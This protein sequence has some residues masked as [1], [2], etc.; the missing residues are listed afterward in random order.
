MTDDEIENR[1]YLYVKLKHT[2]PVLSDSS[3]S[4]ED[5]LVIYYMLNNIETMPPIRGVAKKYQEYVNDLDNWVDFEDYIKDRIKSTVFIKPPEVSNPDMDK[6]YNDLITYS[7]YLNYPKDIQEYYKEVNDYN[8]FYSGPSYIYSEPYANLLEK[9]GASFKEYTTTR[10]IN[11][12]MLKAKYP[13]T[14]DL[15]K[16]SYSDTHNIGEDLAV[17]LAQLEE[18]YALHPAP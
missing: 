11:M 1:E 6:I 8:D 3:L 7:N 18:H 4:F 5:Y 13:K 17:Y 12:D 2:T 9:F 15:L 16:K 14:M 10:Q